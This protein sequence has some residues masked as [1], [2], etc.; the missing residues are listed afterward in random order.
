MSQF[1]IDRPI[2]AWVLAI[3]MMLAGILAIRSLPVSQFPDVAAPAV[4]I[5]M[6]YPGASADTLQDTVTQIIEQQ[7]TGLDGLRYISSESSSNGTMV[8]IATFEQGTNPDIAQVQ[9]QNKLQTAMPML[10]EE[11]QRLGIR[12][13]KFSINYMLV[14]NVYSEDGSMTSG[15]ISDYVVSHMQDPIVR[16]SGV[17]DFT[18]MGSAYA[19]RIW[20]DPDKLY[21]YQLT[22]QD[23]IAA[24]RAQ[25]VQVSAGQMA[26]LPTREHVQFTATIVGKVRMKTAAEF[27]NIL[28]KVKPDGSQVRLRDVAEIGLASESFSI[29]GKYMGRPATGIALTLAHGANLLETVE[30]VRETVSRLETYMPEGMKVA[31]AVD[32]S[33]VVE[34]SIEGVVYTM[35]EAVVLVVLVMFLFLQNLR[36]TLIPTLAVPVVLMATFAVLYALGFTIN[37]MTMFALVL[38]IG[39]L[40]D[41]AIVVVE[42]VE[43][44]MSEEGLSPKEATRKSMKQIQGALVGVGLVISAVFMPMAFFGGSTGV[45]Y[46]QFALTIITAMG[47]SV[48]VALIFTPALCAT[49]LTPLKRGEHHGNRGFFRWFN[50]YFDRGAAAHRKGVTRIL[51]GRGRFML[52]Y[53]VLVAIVALLFQKLPTAFLPDEDQGQMFIIVQLPSNA[54]AERTVRVQEEIRHHLMEQEGHL[55]DHIFATTGYS[56]AGRGQNAGNMYVTLKPFEDRTRPEDSVLA[57]MERTN[58]RLAQIQDGAAFAIVPPALME[59]G[60]ATGFDLYLQDHAALGHEALMAAVGQFLALARQE[61]SLALVRPNSLPDESQYQVII[62]DEKARALQV[63]LADINATMSAAW[64]STYVND[65]IDQGRVKKVYVQ[66][67]MDSRLAPEDFA[68]WYVRNAEGKMVSFASFATGEWG[69]GSPKLQ[70]YNGV[71]AVQIQG[72]PAPGHSTGEAMAALER[73]VKELPSGFDIAFTGLSYE[74]RQA[75]SQAG[76]LYALSVLIVFLCLAALYESWSVPFAVILTVPLGVLGAVFATLGR[77]L[78]N[79]VFFQVGMLTTMGLAAKNAVLIVEFARAQYEKEGKTLVEAALEA[80]RLRLRPI[81]MTSLAFTFGVLPLAIA[82]GASSGSKHAIGTG[83]VGGTI[84]ATFLAIFFVPLFYVVVTGLAER[85]RK[86]APVTGDIQ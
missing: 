58:K 54:S 5:R 17:G 34:A 59:L 24:V 70:R 13:F 18:T 31:Y 22:P 68:K 43:R 20:L 82:S 63:A 85:R 65:F 55:I 6:V 36:A 28:L 86:P 73:I 47:F 10:P 29:Q 76:L 78:S 8:I 56:I 21:S 50:H 62:D 46:R 84:G 72:Q 60:S 30:R 51:A 74:E 80:A 75:G 38:A 79:D 15:E 7:L 25:N 35:M 42:N 57:L 48:L 37:V 52:V 4:A 14:M 12:V 71:P 45:I 33:P 26:A 27:E 3:L 1:F 49:L 2:F 11:V 66:G 44:I 81:I 40:V 23:V 53:L 64:G 9:V 41:D 83:V 32:T 67:N 69:Y 39:L 77:G 16:T 61:P 19:M